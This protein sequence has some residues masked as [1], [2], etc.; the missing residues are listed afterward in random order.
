MMN[1]LRLYLQDRP[2]VSLA[3]LSRQFKQPA[4]VIQGMLSHWLR[5]GRVVLMRAPCADHC[6][7]CAGETEWYRWQENQRAVILLKPVN[8]NHSGESPC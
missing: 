5:K 8:S 2:S 3:E 4:A 1:E 6:G 7:Q